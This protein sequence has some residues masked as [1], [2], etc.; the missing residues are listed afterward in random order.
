MRSKGLRIAV[1]IL[2]ACFLAVAPGQAQERV[3][4]RGL[5]TEHTGE[6]IV[7]KTREGT[8]VNVVVDEDTRVQRPKGLGIRRERVSRDALIPGLRVSVDGT[9]QDATHVRARSV[10]FRGND[11]Q[12]A[13]T[14]QAGLTPTAQKVATN[15]ENIA[16]NTENLK[17][18]EQQIAASQK[19]IATNQQNIVANKTAIDTNAVETGKRFGDLSEFE[20]KGQ[21]D[22][23]FA[24]LSA[25]ISA[26]DQAALKKL[27]QEAIGLKGSVIQVKGFTD[28]RGSTALNQKLS[29]DRAQNVIAF[30]IQECSVPLHSVV[31]PGAMGETTPVS[32]NDTKSGRAENRRV[33]VRVL[34]NKGV[35]GI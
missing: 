4:V 21:L 32:S 7:V 24:T 34:V 27:A 28:S 25:R 11:L 13:E 23:R 16:A 3:R 8:T 1:G 15:Q 6:T 5:I 18:H 14:I 22:V 20:V 12:T 2:A 17:T 26:Q 33:E 9:R 35:A 30:L 19:D 31:G 29:M 10:S